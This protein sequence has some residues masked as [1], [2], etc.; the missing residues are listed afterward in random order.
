MKRSQTDNDMVVSA[1]TAMHE[2]LSE[3]AVKPSI[4][5]LYLKEAIVLMKAE[6]D[7]L[8]EELDA[9]EID[10]KKTRRELA[11]VLNFAG[12]AVFDCDRKIKEL[13]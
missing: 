8:Q 7:E 3:N 2:K 10:Y 4:T 5:D 12:A 13:T 9:D 11:D 6:L 1:V